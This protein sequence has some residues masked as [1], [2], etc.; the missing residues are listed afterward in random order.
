MLV[1]R[2][3]LMTLVAGYHSAHDAARNGIKDAAGTAVGVDLPLSF[4]QPAPYGVRETVNALI[5]T[6]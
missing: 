2:T 5:A 3:E 1:S 6:G 4:A